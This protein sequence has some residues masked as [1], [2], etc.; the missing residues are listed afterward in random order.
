MLVDALRRLVLLLKTDR[1][2]TVNF[3][4]WLHYKATVAILITSSAF[5]MSCQ[6]LGNPI[7]CV[8]DE[9]RAPVTRSTIQPPPERPLTDFADGYCW[10]HSAY[11]MD[12]QPGNCQWPTNGSPRLCVRGEGATS[13][14]RYQWVC[15]VLL[16]QAL[17]FYLPRF[18][19]RTWEG[20]RIELLADDAQCPAAAVMRFEC[21]MSTNGLYFVQLFLCELLNVANAVGQALFLDYFADGQFTTHG[22]D[23]VRLAF[24]DDPDRRRTDPMVHVFPPVKYCIA[25]QKHISPADTVVAS[26]KMCFLPLNAVNERVYVVVWCWLVFVVGVG[27]LS[28]VMRVVQILNEDVRMFLLGARRPSVPTPLDR[29]DAATVVGRCDVA[30]W[31]VLSLLKHNI[32]PDVFDE[33]IAGLA[34]KFESANNV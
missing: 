34:R 2:R 23:A 21:A 5:L 4:F 6:Y 32:D 24:A 10:A 26:E 11:T 8:E 25:S 29:N 14:H 7:R 13:Y 1:V 31:F 27:V 19:W 15:F 3:A 22:L 33:I 9:P 30:D 12:V 28:L 17:Y 16:L 18:L 20:G